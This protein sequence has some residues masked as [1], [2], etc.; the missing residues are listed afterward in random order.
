MGF[1]AIAGRDPCVC[2]SRHPL[3]GGVKTSRRNKQFT[4]KLLKTLSFLFGSARTP[5]MTH[6]NQRVFATLC[7]FHAYTG[8]EIEKDSIRPSLR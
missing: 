2:C 6:L 4:S 8:G 5:N 1:L 7:L 3:V